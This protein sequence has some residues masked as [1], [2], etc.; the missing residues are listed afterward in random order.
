MSAHQHEEG[1]I[2]KNFTLTALL[3][4]ALIFCLFVLL[5]QCHGP[6]KVG[7]HHEAAATEQKA[8]EHA[9]HH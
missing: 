9:E 4:F 3:S 6:Y 5:A 7:G 1:G 2:V 8:E